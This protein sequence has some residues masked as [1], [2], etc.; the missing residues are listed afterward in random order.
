MKKR[1]THSATYARDLPIVVIHWCHQLAE[2]AML[3]R[4]LPPDST[5]HNEMK[6]MSFAFM[7]ALGLVLDMAHSKP[8]FETN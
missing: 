3:I 4:T 2:V 5:R 7:G 1:I 6:P 8:K